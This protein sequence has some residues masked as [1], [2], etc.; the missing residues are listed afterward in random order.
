M[1]CKFE[2]PTT[3]NVVKRVT[4]VMVDY[5]A[6][7]RHLEASKIPYDTFHAESLSPVK[8]VTCQG[9]LLLKISPAN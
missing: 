6:L 3:R 2:L 4:K 8:A 1:K 9:E 5:S 7:M